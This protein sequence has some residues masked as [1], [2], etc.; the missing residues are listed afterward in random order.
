MKSEEMWCKKE[1]GI[2]IN[3]MENEVNSINEKN[4]STYTYPD[5]QHILC[6]AEKPSV[7]EEIAKVLNANRKN[8]KE[9]YFEG[10]GYYVTWCVGH[11]VGLAEPEAYGEEFGIWSMDV[12]PLIPKKWKLEIIE[13]TKYQFYNVKRLINREDVQL[14][15]DC[16]DYGEQGHYIQWLVRIMSGCKKPVK[17]LCAKS[18]TSKELQRAFANLEDINKFNY[19]IAGQFSKAKADWIIGMCLTRYFS[20]KYKENLNKGEVLSVGRV[21]TPTWNF[22]V[23]RYYEIQNFVPETYYQIQLE[24]KTIVRNEIF[25]AAY[26]DVSGDG[27]ILD[28]DAAMKIVQELKQIRQAVVTDVVTEEKSLN[29][30]QLY[31]ITSLQKDG[32]KLYDYSPDDVLKALQSLYEKK[33]MTYPRTDSKYLNTDVAD[34]MEERIRSIALLENYKESAQK[35]LEKGL[36]LDKRVVNNNKVVDHHAII[37]TENIGKVDFN[38]LNIKEKKILHMVIK[39][40]LLSFDEKMIYSETKVYVKAGKYEFVSSGKTILQSG[41][42][43]TEKRLSFTNESEKKKDVLPELSQ[44]DLLS[45]AEVKS[46]K[47]KTQAPSPYT[48]ET[49]LAAME[50]AGDKIAVDDEM[51]PTGIGTGATRAGIVKELYNRGYLENFTKEKRIY[52]QPT[53][54][55]LFAKTV[56]PEALLNP[57]LT[58]RWQY[59]IKQIENKE[60]STDDFLADTISFV[61]DI[62]QEAETSTATFNGLFSDNQEVVGRCKWC[63]KNVYQKRNLYKC[64]NEKCGFFLSDSK[65][66]ISLFYYKKPLTFN[67][68]QKLLSPS[69]LNVKCKS[70]NDNSYTANFKVKSTPKIEGEKKYPDFEM[71]FVPQTQKKVK[72]KPIL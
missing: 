34:E 58:A 44:G 23:D 22:V 71:T 47:R 40:M 42:K 49:L 70:K 53:K 3:N 72:R 18:V 13:E 24:L 57:D 50:N 64:E 51:I 59:K 60:L 9:G 43:D 15:V 37:V 38:S 36:N 56:F 28:A 29:R 65:N 26:L 33:I 20:V 46:V 1:K 5:A 68:M 12:L 25:K 11:L 10:N 17:K 16:G 4:N 2:G 61:K 48:Y 39:R 52:I 7:A 30:P 21:Q 31:D 41:W 27:K 45:I 62:L 69:G 14:V 19:I 67:Q 54:K 35:L 32:S 8:A 55:A 6:I 66:M 63:G